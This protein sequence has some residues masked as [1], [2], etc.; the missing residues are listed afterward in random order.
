MGDA[1]Q[2]VAEQRSWA[3]SVRAEGEW[4]LSSREAEVAGLVADGLANKQIACRLGIT[5]GT[6]KT[7]LGKVFSKLG[8]RNRTQ[9]ALVLDEVRHHKTDRD[10]RPW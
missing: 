9:A 7:H 3:A 8:V 2:R 5:A 10:R 1:G 6:V 4:H